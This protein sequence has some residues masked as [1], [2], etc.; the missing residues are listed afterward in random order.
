[1]AHFAAEFFQII[2][3]SLRLRSRTGSPRFEDSKRIEALGTRMELTQLDQPKCLYGEM[4]VTLLV[5][6]AVEWPLVTLTCPQFSLVVLLKRSTINME[7]GPAMGER[8]E[9][10]PSLSVLLLPITPRALFG[11]DSRVLRE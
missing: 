1:M 6:S 4:L 10:N 9:G 2:L 3:F 5:S 7:E 11:H 8:E